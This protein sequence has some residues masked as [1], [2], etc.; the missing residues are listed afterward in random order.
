MA[1]KIIPSLSMLK[2]LV[3]SD[4][5]VVR[6]LK[7]CPWFVVSDLEKTL[8]PNVEILKR[9]SIP[10]ERV[11]HLLYVFPRVFLVKSDIIRKSVDKAI[12]IGVPLTSIAFIHAVAVLNYTNE[13]MWEVK[14]QTLRDLGFSDDGIVTMFRKQPLVFAASGAKLKNKI[15]FLLATGKFDMANIV[16]CPVALGCSIE[17][18]LEPRLQI[19]RLLESRNLIKKPPVLSSISSFTDSK[20]FDKYIRPYYDEIGEENTIEKF[21]MGKKELKL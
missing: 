6:L 21:V 19:L 1:N 20:F 3:G 13:G 12:E 8:M 9:C 10:T 17:N 15:E 2:G 5:D 18:R 14:L 7:K 4:D 16:T 11:L